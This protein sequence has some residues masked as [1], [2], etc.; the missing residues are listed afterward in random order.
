VSLEAIVGPI[1]VWVYNE[2]NYSKSERS[3]MTTA[4]ATSLISSPITTLQ[5]VVETL[6]DGHFAA[7]MSAL[8]DCRVVAESRAEAIVALELHMEKRLGSI[9]VIEMPIEST[10]LAEHSLLKLAGVLKDDA[11]FAAWHDRFWAEKQCIDDDEQVSIEELMG[12]L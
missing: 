9:E 2:E 6:P 12:I 11:D 1:G 3:V 7:W 4:I 8:P 10:P 5:A